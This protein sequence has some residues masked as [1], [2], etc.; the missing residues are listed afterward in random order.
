MVGGFEWKHP[1]E[2]F[3]ILDVQ[4]VA[5]FGQDVETCWKRYATGDRL[6]GVSI[7]I[8]IIIIIYTYINNT[9][10]PD[11]CFLCTAEM[12]PASFFLQLLSAMPC[13]PLWALWSPTL[14][15]EYSVPSWWN[16]WGRIRRCG[17]TAEGVSLGMDSAVSQDSHHS[18]CALDFLLVSVS[19]L[20]FLSP[21]Q[22]GL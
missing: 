5:L 9:Q 1:A 11:C 17:L 3:R 14:M 19:S 8:V 12:G 4:L 16:C 7:I 18:R 20:L 2:A 15:F 13:L 6:W 10:L 22:H 21:C